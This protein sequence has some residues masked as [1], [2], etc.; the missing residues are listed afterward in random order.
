MTAGYSQ[1]FNH[2]TGD[3]DD[4]YLINARFNREKFEW[5]PIKNIAKCDPIQYLSG[6]D[7]LVNMVNNKMN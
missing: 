2:D 6:F 5:L 4:C 3:E 7:V 1:I